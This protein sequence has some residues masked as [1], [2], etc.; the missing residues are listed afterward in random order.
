MYIVQKG[1]FAYFSFTGISIYNSYFTH[2]L[3]E[4]YFGNVVVLHGI[5]QKRRSMAS[6]GTGTFFILYCINL[7]KRIYTPEVIYLAHLFLDTDV[8][9]VTQVRKCTRVRS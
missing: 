7:I 9:F 3:K 8:F 5:V 4:Q 6:R 2:D 1:Y